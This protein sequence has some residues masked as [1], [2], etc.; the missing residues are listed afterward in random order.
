MDKFKEFWIHKG[1][2]NFCNELILGDD[3]E[4]FVKANPDEFYDIVSTKD[5]V[6]GAIHVIEYEAYEEANQ[7]LET[8]EE[9][10]EAALK[11]Y[12]EA[13]NKL[14]TYEDKVYHLSRRVEELE[15][16]LK[17]ANDRE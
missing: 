1:T 12:Q 9:L 8:T 13:K 10:L 5:T 11:D 2:S 3:Y 14:D 17:M 7:V 16:L 6:E 4:T 15:H